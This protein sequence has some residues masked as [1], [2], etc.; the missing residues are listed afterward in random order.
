L[1]VLCQAA[2]ERLLP[3][4]QSALTVEEGYAVAYAMVAIGQPSV[5]H[6]M[7]SLLSGDVTVAMLRGRR[8]AELAD[9][10]RSVASRTMVE[11][12]TLAH[13]AALVCPADRASVCPT[14]GFDEARRPFSVLEACVAQ[15]P[16]PTPPALLRLGGY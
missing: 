6:Y 12:P 13:L 8:A 5:D 7:S 9:A 4:E 10:S 15:L 16:P 14:E 3:R 11:C 1:L 2:I